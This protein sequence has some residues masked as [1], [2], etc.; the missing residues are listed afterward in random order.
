M[1]MLVVHI[2][3]ISMR[4][5]GSRA[6]VERSVNPKLVTLLGTLGVSGLVCV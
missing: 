2:T 6:S 4:F 1:Q 3:M 5:P